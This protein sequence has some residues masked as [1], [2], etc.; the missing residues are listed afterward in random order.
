MSEIEQSIEFH[1]SVLSE[2]ARAG[3]DLVLVLSAYIHRW[4]WQGGHWAGVGLS[5]TAMIRIGRASLPDPMPELP[6][7][8]ADGAI[9]TP[10]TTLDNMIPADCARDGPV[11]LRLDFEG[12]QALRIEGDSIRVELRGEGVIIESLPDK[13]RRG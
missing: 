10:D 3:P 12:D 13:M 11:V 1:D 2:I 5:Q 6:S 4:E 9:S 7:Q 8:I